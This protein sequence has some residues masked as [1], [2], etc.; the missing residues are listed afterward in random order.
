MRLLREPLVQIYNLARDNPAVMVAYQ[1]VGADVKTHLDAI[2]ELWYRVSESADARVNF[3]MTAAELNAVKNARRLIYSIMSAVWT[4]VTRLLTRLES[5]SAPVNMTIERAEMELLL[6]HVHT[7]LQGFKDMDVAHDRIPLE[8][9]HLAAIR[10]IRERLDS[11]APA[12]SNSV[13]LN[14]RPGGS[15]AASSDAR[16]ASSSGHHGGYKKRVTR[17]RHFKGRSRR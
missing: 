15:G 17:R 7:F 13:L 5:L 6:E 2:E 1:A 11:L 4:E 8:N 14:A 10:R 12:A 9:R 3:N 16:A